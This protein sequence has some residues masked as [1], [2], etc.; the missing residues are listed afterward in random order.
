MLREGPGSSA[1]LSPLLSRCPIAQ[2]PVVQWGNTR[3]ASGR[4]DRRPEAFASDAR[5]GRRTASTSSAVRPAEAIH[6]HVVSIPGAGSRGES[7]RARSGLGRG[8]E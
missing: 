5:K 7:D 3:A 1:G 6:V 4:Y 8:H 2:R